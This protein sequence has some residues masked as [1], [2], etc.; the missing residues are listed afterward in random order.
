MNG[1]GTVNVTGVLYLPYTNGSF[2]GNVQLKSGGNCFIALLNSFATNGT[3]YVLDMSKCKA[4]GVGALPSVLR[5]R[6][7]L[8]Q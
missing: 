7:A 1:N 5:Y 2:G 6:A 4:D 3:G 8:V